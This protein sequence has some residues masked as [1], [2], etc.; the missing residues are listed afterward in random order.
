VGHAH[1]SDRYREPERRSAA[2]GR[3]EPE[4]WPDG[5]S[6]E[7][8]AEWTGQA[9]DRSRMPW[10]DEEIREARS[11]Q[12]RLRG[13]SVR[14]AGDP[15]T[16]L[17]PQERDPER[18]WKEKEQ[19]LFGGWSGGGNDGG[20]EPRSSGRL[21]HTFRIQLAA[22][23]VLFAAVWSVFHVQSPATEPARQAVREV[24]TKEWN[25][26]A[27]S[28][29]YEQQFG[30]LP[31]FLPAFHG[32]DNQTTKVNAKLTEPYAVPVT[33]TVDSS[34]AEATPWIAVK[35]AVGTSVKAIDS[36]MVA[37]SADVDGRH[38]LT[39]RHAGGIESTYTGLQ[40]LTLQKG[41][42]VQKG[43]TI[44]RVARDA[45]TGQGQ[46]RLAIRKD[47][48]FVDPLEWVRLD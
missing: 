47:G 24:M 8:E 23:I 22:S 30:T 38:S 16:P 42:W 4:R 37:D 21:G 20:D 9:P 31:S 19:Q 35:V 1:D 32:K 41:D 14:G 15:G 10:T 45:E 13:D 28:A 39:V 26:A 2:A 7:R 25:F 27:M 43:E 29:W 40:E 33:G 5:W 44:G 12:Q 6:D 34:F 3:N 17:G 36:G 18:V 48:L 11:V 46:L